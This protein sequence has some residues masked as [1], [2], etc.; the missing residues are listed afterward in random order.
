MGAGLIL[1]FSC[2]QGGCHL[3][4]A[5]REYSSAHARWPKQVA[6]WSEIRL[7][8]RSGCQGRP[9]THAVFFWQPIFSL[10]VGLA[11]MWINRNGMALLWVVFGGMGNVAA[12]TASTLFSMDHNL[13][14]CRSTWHEAQANSASRAE[15]SK[16]IIV[17][18]DCSPQAF[19]Q[20]GH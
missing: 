15:G 5:Q 9:G 14:S 6:F 20:N 19:P 12:T 11:A 3:E 13:D 18:R 4:R 17:C 10:C 16:C 2:C 8:P 7:R 1:L